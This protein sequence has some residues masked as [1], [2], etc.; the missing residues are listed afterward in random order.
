M[1][2]I[3]NKVCDRCRKEIKYVGWTS[4]LKG[5]GKPTRIKGLSLFNGNPDG[6]SYS[7]WDRELCAECSDKL[8]AFLLNKK[9]ESE[10]NKE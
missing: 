5:I 2:T 3:P 6:Y 9:Y 4:K 10:E 1:A 8:R 7:E